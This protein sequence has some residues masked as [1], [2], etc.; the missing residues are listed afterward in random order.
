MRGYFSKFD[1]D[2]RTTG[3][4]YYRLSKIHP[5]ARPTFGRTMNVLFG[6]GDRA[7]NTA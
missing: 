7:G 1:S 4:L 2:L 5:E 6:T 3:T